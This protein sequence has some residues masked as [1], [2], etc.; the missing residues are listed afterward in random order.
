MMIR[1]NVAEEM[2]IRDDENDGC[3]LG[4]ATKY[5]RERSLPSPPTLIT[6]SLPATHITLHKQVIRCTRTSY[7]RRHGVI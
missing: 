5:Q 3:T 6:S 7:T 1:N 4:G 2:M